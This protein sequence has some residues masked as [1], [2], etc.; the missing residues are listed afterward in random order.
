MDYYFQGVKAYLCCIEMFL[1]ETQIHLSCQMISKVPA[2]IAEKR[3]KFCACSLSSVCVC[4]CVCVR[5][6]GFAC[7]RV[8]GGGGGWA[9]IFVVKYLLL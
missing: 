4:V 8:C 9:C 7:G 2:I 5:A 1:V 3:G 6:C